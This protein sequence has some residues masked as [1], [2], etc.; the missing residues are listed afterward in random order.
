MEMEKR[1]GK[2]KYTLLN[3]DKEGS[4]DFV[5][6]DERFSFQKTK[7]SISFGIIC[8]SEKENKYP[9]SIFGN[10]LVR[11]FVPKAYQRVDERGM[12]VIIPNESNKENIGVGEI[13]SFT[14]M[15]TRESN[16]YYIVGL[17]TLDLS[18]NT[19]S[20]YLY[21][22]DEEEN[23]KRIHFPMEDVDKKEENKMKDQENEICF[24]SMI[25]FPMSD[26][27]LDLFIPSLGIESIENTKP[28]DNEFVCS[29]TLEM[30]EN[31]E[32]TNNTSN[33]LDVLNSPQSKQKNQIDE[34]G[35][36][37]TNTIK[38][39]TSPTYPDISSVRRIEAN[40]N[41][42]VAPKKQLDSKKQT[43][44]GFFF[45][46][47]FATFFCTAVI[48]LVMSNIYIST[49]VEKHNVEKMMKYKIEM[50]EMQSQRH[51]EYLEMMKCE[52]E[53]ELQ[54]EKYH[55][56]MNKMQSQRYFEMI[57]SE[58]QLAKYRALESMNEIKIKRYFFHKRSDDI[59]LSNIY[60]I[61]MEN[62]QSLITTCTETPLIFYC[63]YREPKK[64]LLH[65]ENWLKLSVI[66]TPT[67]FITN[68]NAKSEKELQT[69]LQ[70]V[71]AEDYNSFLF[72]RE[73][74][75]HLYYPDYLYVV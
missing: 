41:K 9:I 12:F 43:N 53:L 23:K 75:S 25:S 66:T 69:F 38:E 33:R 73:T 13:I 8:G 44:I 11:V 15:C 47:I 72:D 46:V 2:L 50:N 68:I 65:P 48:T 67:I 17:T 35:D 57:K 29:T 22:L 21:S 27:L 20:L 32:E 5:D 36:V 30:Q 31:Q 71:G 58:I 10:N 55:N 24:V 42:R 70:S 7:E 26:S 37:E 28:C 60:F 45:T 18:S 1:S 63:R 56:L 16:S 6:Y 64:I 51:S 14:D 34:K 19:P 3:N 61:P 74:I 39:Q 52:I 4:I 54:L 62:N 40:K 49:V 59:L